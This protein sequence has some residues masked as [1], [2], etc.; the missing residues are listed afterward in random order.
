MSAYLIALA[1]AWTAYFI[2]HS[3]LAAERTKRWVAQHWPNLAPSYRLGF[4]LVSLVLLL[5]ILYYLHAWPG[6]MLW[7]WEGVWA[8]LA[9]GLALAAA[10]GF[11]WTL[12]DY[13]NAQFL[14]L[15][16]RRQ[17]QLRPEQDARLTISPLHRHVR[18][19]W[20]FFGL[21]ILWTRNMDAALLV[22]AVVITLYLW[23]GSRLEERK[24]LHQFGAAYARYCRRVPGLFPLPWRHL[25]AQEARELE[26]AGQ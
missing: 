4:N 26:Q 23:L 2:L 24:L 5:P 21:V 12:R 17:G 9:N 19:P 8:W 14:G 25:S 15:S 22:S 6:P 1:T 7:T 20:Y 16:Q 11:L 10:A 13:D 18:H 3:A